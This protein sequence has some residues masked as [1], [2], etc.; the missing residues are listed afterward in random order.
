MKRSLVILSLVL[1]VCLV[2]G[3]PAYATNVS[4]T[5]STSTTWDLAGSPY[6][7]T[8]AINVQG[9]SAPVLT[10]QSGVTVQFNSG[11]YIQVGSSQPGGITA[12]GTPASPIVFTGSTLSPGQWRILIQ[13]NTV[14]TAQFTN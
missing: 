14:S 6:V 12:I 7:V 9:A 8:G 13:S 1:A 4:G 2:G 3:Y 11:T 10:I 5:I